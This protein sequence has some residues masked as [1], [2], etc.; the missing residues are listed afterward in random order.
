[1]S[2]AVFVGLMTS[3]VSNGTTGGEA[4]NITWLAAANLNYTGAAA[5]ALVVTADASS[6]NG[7]VAYSVPHTVI[8]NCNKQPG[9]TG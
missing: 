5:R 8:A 6:T 3:A 9:A 4:G 1:M 2:S 7:A